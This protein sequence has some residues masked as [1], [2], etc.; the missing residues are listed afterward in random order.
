MDLFIKTSISSILESINNYVWGWGLICLILLTGI[1]YTLK[2]G[3]P[4]F[5]MIEFLVK[6]TKKE[7]NRRKSTKNNEDCENCTKKTGISQFKT[8]TASLG[9]AMGTGNIV[10]VATAISVGGA[11]AVFWIWVS[12]FLGMALVYAENYLSMIYRKKDGNNWLG[13]TICYLKYGV[14]SDILAL[15]F[16]I[17][18]IFASFG[19]GGMVQANSIANAVGESQKSR[20]IIAIL[21][22]IT[23]FAV[24]SGGI[25]R[26][27]SASQAIIPFLTFAYIAVSV[28]V[29]IK[30]HERLPEAFG[31]IFKSAFDFKSAGGFALSIGIRRGIF[32]NEAGLGSSPIMHSA[33][34]NGS[35]SA[36]GMW[37]IFEVFLDT[38]VCCTL[39][40]LVVI[41]TGNCNMNGAFSCILG[42]GSSFFVSIAIILFAFCTVTGWYYCGESSFRYIFRNR[43]IKEYR[44]LF[45]FIVSL[46]A[47]FSL[48]DVWTLSDIFNGLMAFPNLL[49]LIM[50]C[51]KVKSG[52]SAV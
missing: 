19:M 43:Y 41:V 39:T 17:F 18:C 7:K 22:F 37:S 10:G 26:I 42:N 38:I 52:Q 12:A 5:R 34:E 27:G 11:G 28:G 47:V 25:K 50:L 44:F 16:S 20:I 33:S 48:E 15:I 6:S 30:Y 23:V 45:A 46:G 32:S 31:N 29:L 3:F 24:I 36:Q 2:L 49:A 40:A 8:V 4:Q 9:T 1:I 13:G 21:I 14:G 51:H 35:P